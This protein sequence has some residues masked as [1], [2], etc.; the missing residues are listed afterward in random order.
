MKARSNNFDGPWLPF[1]VLALLA[2]A[3]GFVAMYVLN[4]ASAVGDTALGGTALVAEVAAAVRD[5]LSLPAGAYRD[6]LAVVYLMTD[7]GA[8]GSER[9]EMLR[10]SIEL[11]DVYLFP[12]T[13]S[14]VYAFTSRELVEQVASGLG[15]AGRLPNVLVLPLNASTGGGAGAGAGGG[16]GVGAAASAA[17]AAAAGA[18]AHRFVSDWRL[19]FVPAFAKALGHRYVLQLDHD[20]F[21]LSPPA[22]GGSLVQLMEARGALLA[23]RSTGVA[24]PEATLGLPELARHFLVSHRLAPTQLWGFCSPPGLEGLH[25]RQGQGDQGAA[26]GKGALA[27]P[28]SGGW[29]GSVLHGS[30]LA[31][32]VDWWHSPLVSRFVQLCRAAGDSGG[33]SQHWTDQGVV[34]MLWQ[35]LLAPQQLHML[36]FEFVHGSFEEARAKAKAVLGE[37]GGPS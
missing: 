32:S 26:G 10:L 6:R 34:A 22:P 27:L 28:P 36:Q 18:G 13:P 24:P 30:Y 21:V 16:G 20:S 17:Q 9:A 37:R 3:G 4:Q 31:Y 1:A 33:A 2:T 19:S 29:N 11:L 5:H 23:A 14:L 25:S 8:K 15:A 35:M 12:T 7:M